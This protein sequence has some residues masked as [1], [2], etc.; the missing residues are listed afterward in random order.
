MQV[1]ENVEHKSVE[2]SNFGI[3]VYSVYD[4]VLK[5]YDFPICVPVVK[6]DDYM[7][8]LVNDVNS[9][10]FNHESDYILNSYY[11]PLMT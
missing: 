1:V 11:H 5:Q 7:K 6:L 4:C 3:G 10:Y 2:T 8:L 9:K